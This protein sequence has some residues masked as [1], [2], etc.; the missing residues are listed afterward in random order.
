MQVGAGFE[1]VTHKKC[2]DARFMAAHQPT[3]CREG[4]ST[5]RV[6][7]RRDRPPLLMVVMRKWKMMMLPL[8]MVVV[9]MMGMAMAVVL[10]AVARSP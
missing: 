2:V 9:R 4:R 5:R 6:G 10:C 7:Q 3:M 1:F 8:L